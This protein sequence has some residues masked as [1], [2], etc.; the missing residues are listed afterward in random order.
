MFKYSNPNVFQMFKYSNIQIFKC[1]N[2]NIVQM[3]WPTVVSHKIDD[4]SPLWEFSARNIA[5]FQYY[6]YQI[7]EILPGF[8]QIMNTY[9]NISS[10]PPACQELYLAK[11][12]KLPL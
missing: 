12:P 11:M 1:S 4:E 9:R 2:T 3:F 5:R 10:N 7:L 8:S 6:K